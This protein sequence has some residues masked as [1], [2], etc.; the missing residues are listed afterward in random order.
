MLFVCFPHKVS[1]LFLPKIQYDAE[2][3][4]ST[5]K[6]LFVDGSS[7]RTAPGSSQKT[8]YYVLGEQNGPPGKFPKGWDIALKGMVIGE[9]RR[10]TLPYSLAYGLK[11]NKEL[12]IPPRSNMIYT[13]KLISLT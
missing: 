8:I 2:I 4:D 7:L 13:V 6:R 1:N 3:E 11:G 9:V 5:G 12:N 10:I